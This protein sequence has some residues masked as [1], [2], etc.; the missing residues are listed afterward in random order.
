[1]GTGASA[2]FLR[3]SRIDGTKEKV[4]MVP[5]LVL[6]IKIRKNNVD[7]TVVIFGP[8]DAPL[9]H[10]PKW[11]VY[12]EEPTEKA[13]SILYSVQLSGQLWDVIYFS[14]CTKKHC[15]FWDFL[16]LCLVKISSKS[17][18]SWKSS[19]FRELSLGLEQSRMFR[20]FAFKW[21]F[22]VKC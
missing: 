19:I 12:I 13:S 7:L 17:K 1:M 2:T 9:P 16:D 6:K 22:F 4:P 10:Q 8:D 18:S 21:L 20:F 14:Q 11:N 15:S 5:S 3:C